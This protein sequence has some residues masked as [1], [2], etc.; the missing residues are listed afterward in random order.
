MKSSI[1][2]RKEKMF[3]NFHPIAEFLKLRA[4][5]N[6]ITRTLCVCR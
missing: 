2:T 3:I 6:K 1:L 5:S 4:E